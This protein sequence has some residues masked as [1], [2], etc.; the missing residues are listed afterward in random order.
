[1][2]V[3]PLIALTIAYIGIENLFIKN[4]D[5]RWVLTFFF[6][7]I[8]GLGFAGV[9]REM[10]LPTETL[11]TSLVSFNVGVELGQVVIVSFLYPF[12]YVMGKYAW[13]KRMVQGLSFSIIF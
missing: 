6:G 11:I 7:L 3:E 1:M 4:T 9:L 12:I 13:K 10:N 5:K 2:I 8:H